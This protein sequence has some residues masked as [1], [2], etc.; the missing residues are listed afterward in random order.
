MSEKVS[1]SAGT[2]YGKF[3]EYSNEFDGERYSYTDD[4]K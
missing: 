2:I 4:K 3:E 1:F